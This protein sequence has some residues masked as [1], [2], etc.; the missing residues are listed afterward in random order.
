MDLGLKDRVAIIG[1]SSRG[2]GRAIALAFAQEGASVTICARTEADLRR[3]EIELARLSSQHHVLAIPA[4][5]GVARDI[6]RVVRDTINRFGQVGILVTH[7]G[8]SESG[9]PSEF[10]DETIGAAMEHNFLSA[11][12]LAREVVPYMKQ[13]RWGR[14]I[15][16]LPTQVKQAPEGVVLSLSGQMAL[17]GYSKMLANELAPSNITVNNV[18]AGPVKTE[19]FTASLEAKAEEQDRNLEDLLKET[20]AGIPMKRLGKPEEVG[21]LVAFLASERAGYLTGTN[22]VIDGGRLQTIN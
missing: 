9:R 14:I 20:S 3:T 10:D 1:G 17:V 11:V 15:H 8:Q 13:Q 6:R 18:L 22:V 16:L 5:L 12:R 7:I 19:F 21:D 2:I 4:D